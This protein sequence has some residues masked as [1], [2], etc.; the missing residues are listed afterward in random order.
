MIVEVAKILGGLALD[1]FRNKREEK[2]AEHEAKMKV[3]ANKAT[4]E[5]TAQKNAGDSFKDEYWTIIV[6]LPFIGAFIPPLVPYVMEGFAALE[7]MPDYYKMFVGASIGASFGY[8]KL[9][10]W[11]K[12]GH[13]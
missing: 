11:K 13:D 8:K 2:Q 10:D 6:S 9:V 12:Q 5:Q 3:I 7:H 1:W 4:W